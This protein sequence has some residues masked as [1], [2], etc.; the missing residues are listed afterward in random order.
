MSKGET[1]PCAPEPGT[2]RV[3]NIF[4]EKASPV[5]STSTTYGI[6]LIRYTCRVLESRPSNDSGMCADAVYMFFFVFCFELS[7]G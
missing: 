2:A 1:E 6:L 3:F 7:Q 5:F 4:E